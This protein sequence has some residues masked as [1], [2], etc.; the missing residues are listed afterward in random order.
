MGTDTDRVV[1]PGIWSD[2]FIGLLQQGKARLKVE[3][4]DEEGNSVWEGSEIPVSDESLK[5]INNIAMQGISQGLGDILRELKTI[6][7]Y[8]AEAFGDEP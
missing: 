3:L 6:N 8:L 1:V 2:A 7:I 5:Y 4:V